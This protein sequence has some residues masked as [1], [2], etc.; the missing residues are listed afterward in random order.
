MRISSIL[1]SSPSD[2]LSLM[3]GL[4][5]TALFKNKRGQR[6]VVHREDR[7]CARILYRYMG[8]MIPPVELDVAGM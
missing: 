3:I 1:G 5:F 8:G 6:L 4:T 2:I 7:L